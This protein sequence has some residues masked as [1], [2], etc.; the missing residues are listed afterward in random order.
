MTSDNQGP[1]RPENQTKEETL[2]IFG[3]NKNGLSEQEASR[4]LKENGFNES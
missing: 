4:R 3:S 2:E 1:R